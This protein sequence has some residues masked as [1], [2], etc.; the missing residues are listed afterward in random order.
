MYQFENQVRVRYAETDQMG[1]VYYGN[2]AIYCEVARVESLR[3]LGYSYKQLEK[4]GV[5]MPVMEH[6]SKYLK[7]AKYDELITIKTT[8]PKPPSVKISFLYDFFNEANEK[9]H[10]AQTD[11]VFTKMESGKPCRPPGIMI[12]LFA[13][14][15]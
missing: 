14:F 3:N 6:R 2:Y 9:I 10:E 15:Y 8:V 5:M 1:Y 11:L 7:P 4:S 12:S 13:D